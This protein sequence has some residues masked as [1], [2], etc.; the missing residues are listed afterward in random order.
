MVKCRN[1]APPPR[2]LERQTAGTHAQ[3]R[4]GSSLL[5]PVQRRRRSAARS[6]SLGGGMAGHGTAGVRLIRR[7]T[8]HA[9][10]TR[11]R[12]CASARL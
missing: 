6:A 5:Q 2:E 4:A 3:H 12:V 9:S 8:R 7:L 11:L 1:E 10:L